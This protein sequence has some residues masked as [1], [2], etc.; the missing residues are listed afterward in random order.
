MPIESA[1]RRALKP[2]GGFSRIQI[3]ARFR[4]PCFAMKSAHELASLNIWRRWTSHSLERSFLVSTTT[5]P[6]FWK[7]KF[8]SWISLEA[9]IES[10]LQIILP[11]SNYA[12]RPLDPPNTL[13]KKERIIRRNH[14]STPLHNI[15]VPKPE[16]IYS[17]YI[18]P[19][20]SSKVTILQSME[21]TFLLL[22]AA[23]T[24]RSIRNML[25]VA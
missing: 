13:K 1:R 20:D 7:M 11:I 18:F 14:L 23:A 21:N 6:S 12:S 4:A 2:G 25:F 5:T 22:V 24:D 10:K 16:S 3:S 8:P 9:F 19:Y 15:Y 17:S